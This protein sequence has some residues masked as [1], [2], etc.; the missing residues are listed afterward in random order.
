MSISKESKEKK[1]SLFGSTGV[2]SSSTAFSR[3]L[4]LVREQVMAYYFGA[5]MATDAFL[6]A[7]IRGG[8]MASPIL[9]RP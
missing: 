1:N 5:G 9:K 2:V 6:T 7:L 8:D 3:V 4:G